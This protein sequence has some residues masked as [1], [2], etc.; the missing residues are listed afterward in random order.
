MG[1]EKS[2]LVY[3][4]CISTHVLLY[5]L[6]E[7]VQAFIIVVVNIATVGLALYLGSHV[8]FATVKDLD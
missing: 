8:L 2:A 5:L 7:S 4:L 6:L 3:L 1:E